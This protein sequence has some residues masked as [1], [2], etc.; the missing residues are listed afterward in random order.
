MRIGKWKVGDRVVRRRHIG[1]QEVQKFADSVGDH[2]PI[3]FD[4][5]AA[6]KAGFRRRI[7]HGMIASSMFS[8][9][10]G[11]EL[12]GPGS[13][14]ASQTLRFLAPI[15]VPSDIELVVELIRVR[16]DKP[17]VTVRTVC[18]SE[19]DICIDGEAVLVVRSL[20]EEETE[21]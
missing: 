21:P 2:N 17:V 15:L 12:P 19:G 20:S 4:D 18:R 5:L 3:H 13:V 7:A 8:D 16:E 10:L 11:N 1:T 9:I 14:Y 6:Q